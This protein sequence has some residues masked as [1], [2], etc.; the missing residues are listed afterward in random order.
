MP[1]HDLKILYKTLD[2]N[3]KYAFAYTDYQAIVINT[4]TH[5]IGKNY[6]HKSKYFRRINI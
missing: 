5:P 4:E 1:A 3:Q 2:I 6:Y